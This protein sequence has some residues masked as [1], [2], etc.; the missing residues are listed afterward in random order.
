MLRVSLAASGAEVAGLDAEKLDEMPQC[1]SVVGLKRYLSHQVGCSR[2]RQ[3]I[4][5][6]NAGELGD[7]QEICPSVDLQLVIL[8]FWPSEE[9]EDAKLISA[10]EHNE[11]HTVEEMLHRPQNPDTRDRDGWARQGKLHETVA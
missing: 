8:D 6:G 5:N 9:L 1:R 10:C 7:D 4:L 11:V 2:F 3:R